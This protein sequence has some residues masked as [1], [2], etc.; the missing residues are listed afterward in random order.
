MPSE[1]APSSNDGTDRDVYAPAV[2]S[3]PAGE[4]KHRQATPGGL[5]IDWSGRCFPLVGEVAAPDQADEG[6]GMHWIEA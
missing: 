1:F 4:T 3:L 2:Q 6:E 5:L